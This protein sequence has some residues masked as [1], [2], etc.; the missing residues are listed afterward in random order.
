M[1]D[2]QPTFTV[3]S[4]AQRIYEIRG[5]RIMLDADLAEMYGVSAKVL[6]QA[7]KRNAER[8]PEDFMFRITPEEADSLRSQ[9]VTLKSGRGQ[10]RKYLPSAFTEQGVS[11][12]SSVLRSTRAIQVN[13]AIIRAFVWLRRAVPAYKELAAKVAELENAVGRHDDAIKTIVQA[14]Q[15][16]IVPPD[17]KQRKIGF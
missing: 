13:I 4:V 14:L 10:H 6:N 5:Q 16:M 1:P 3:D 8:F 2:I 17:D 7:V 12:L 11:M 15:Q 9:I